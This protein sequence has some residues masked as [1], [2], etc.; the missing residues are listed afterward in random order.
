VHGW[1]GRLLRLRHPS[2]FVGTLTVLCQFQSMTG[3]TLAHR[4]R[5]I[6][7]KLKSAYLALMRNWPVLRCSCLTKLPLLPHG[8]A[9][10]SSQQQH[11]AQ[12]IAMS[13]AVKPCE[14]WLCL[15]CPLTRAGRSS[16][17]VVFTED[18]LLQRHSHA[19]D[20]CWTARS[21]EAFV[22]AQAVGACS[23]PRS[24]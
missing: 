19:C 13:G 11:G 14:R 22:H 6:L 2:Q 10:Q 20:V 24:W 4:H 23:V 7:V 16:H 15:C 18:W 17:E 1:V 21:H 9:G 3:C 12:C 8:G 5:T